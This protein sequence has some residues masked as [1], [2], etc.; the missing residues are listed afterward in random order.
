MPNMDGL[1]AARAIRALPLAHAGC[2]PILAMSANTSAAD[3]QRSLDAG[4]NAHLCKPLE[5]A[6]LC[7]CLTPRQST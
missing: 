5:L 2:V 4:M 1:A 3:V 6:A 7:A